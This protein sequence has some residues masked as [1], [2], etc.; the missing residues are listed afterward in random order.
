MVYNPDV[1]DPGNVNVGELQVELEQH[2]QHHWMNAPYYGM[3]ITDYY[4]GKE[5]NS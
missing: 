2:G 1:L 3:G 5:Y 4:F